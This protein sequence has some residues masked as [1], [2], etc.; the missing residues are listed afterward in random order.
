MDD[1]FQ[2]LSVQLARKVTLMWDETFLVVVP[3]VKVL[4]PV[5]TIDTSTLEETHKE[6]KRPVRKK[7]TRLTKLYEEVVVNG[8]KSMSTHH[9][10]I[11]LVRSTLQEHGIPYEVL[12]GRMQD[13]PPPRFDL[14]SGFRFSQR[15]LTEQALMQRRSGLIGAPTR[16]GKCLDP[17]TPV[18]MHDGSV[19]QV[20]HIKVGDLVMGRDSKPR[21]VAKL[22]SGTDIMYK[23]IP[24][25]GAP[26]TVTRDHKLV[27]RRTFQGGTMRKS[28]SKY[29]DYKIMSRKS[30]NHDGT[31]S[32]VTPEEWEAGS[33]TFKHLRKLVKCAVEF[34]HQ[35]TPVDPYCMGLWLGD[36]TTARPSLTT[37][38]AECREAWE[39]EARAHGLNIQVYTKEDNKAVTLAL[40]RHT[41]GCRGVKIADRRY[42][43]LTIVSEAT[44]EGIKRIPDVFRLNSR[45]TRMALLAGLIDSDGYVC[46]TKSTGAASYGI[47][48]KHQELMNDV[49]FLAGSLG[50]RVTQGQ[51][52]A[53]AHANHKA[54]YYTVHING[55]LDTIP[56]RLKRK[57]I[58]KSKGVKPNPMLTGFKVVKLGPGPYCGFEVEGDD[59]TFLLGDFTVT[60]NS[61]MLL[62]T[63]RAYPTLCAIVT[64]PNVDLVDQLYD[65]LKAALPDR[66]V[67][68]LHGASKGKTLSPDI[69]VVSFDSLDHPNI[70]PSLVCLLLI[71]EPHAVPTN[72]RMPRFLR[73]NRALKYGYGATL[74][75]RFDGR[76][77]LIVGIIGP[78]LAERTYR[79]AVAEG[80]IAPLTV[81]G[82][83]I[84]VRGFDCYDRNAAYKIS[85][86]QN[87]SIGQLM[88][89]MLQP[90][91]IIP[92]AWQVLAFI[93]NEKQLDCLRAA[94]KDV[95]MGEAMAKLMTGKQRSSMRARMKSGEE[96]FC[97][98]THIYA[99]GVTF[100]DLRMMINLE[101]GGASTKALQKPGRV[102]ELRPGK[103]CGVILDFIFYASA[104]EYQRMPRSQ[105]WA[106]TRESTARLKSYEE[107]GF[108]V[109]LV[110]DYTELTQAVQATY[111]EPI[112]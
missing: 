97:A 109:V 66:D 40:C 6:G 107:I 47:I 83:R 21:K 81:I 13:L 42:A 95:P 35:P 48:G 104:S 25:K 110:N 16:Y 76:D 111:D 87:E 59:H 93:N 39:T 82:L 96:R 5:L 46:G 94:M 22:V 86:W 106:L 77:E 65:E 20:R 34:S 57:K 17:I 52:W 61:T 4:H 55:D 84:P 91:G 44:P 43:W 58:A 31:E 14:M 38:D 60:H 29:A 49:A 37:A 63:L 102:A 103:K 70:D 108:N 92:N 88:H 2:N 30:P 50:F 101:G 18:L 10:F 67:R 71:D 19:K 74:E 100:S 112:T 45:A 73:F 64:A 1:L 23:V 78:V 54:L 56:V 99:Q 32:L 80:A 53:S 85:L 69:T 36:G 7:V 89:W 90:G 68:K 15:A 33:K 24:N 79:E 11:D 3:D 27:V 9:G 72:T 51:R 98:A 62:N 12:D 105:C 41:Q 26:F 8:T 75:G 28:K